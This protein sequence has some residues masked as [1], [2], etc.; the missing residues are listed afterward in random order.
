MADPNKRIALDVMGGDNNRV[1]IVT[2]DGVESLDDMPKAAVAMALAER[3]AN[4]L[5]AEAAE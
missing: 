3:I 1:H 5:S 2:A 4:T